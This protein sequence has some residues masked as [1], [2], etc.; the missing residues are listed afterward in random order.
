MKTITRI[1]VAVCL[2]S[3]LTAGVQAAYVE[4]SCPSRVTLGDTI[5]VRGES[6]LSPGFSTDVIFSWMEVTKKIIARHEITVQEGGDFATSFDTEGLDPG[7]YMVEI[8]DP[9]RDTFGSSSRTFQMVKVEDRS[10]QISITSPMTQE[11]D[12]TLLVEGAISGNTGTGVKIEVTGDPGVV[13][14]P[15]YIAT[16]TG[17]R[18]SQEVRITEPGEYEVSFSDQ[19]G[20]IGIETF[21]VTPAET[22]TTAQ[23]TTPLT[24]S[25]SASASSSRE[26]PAYF[27]IQARRGTVEVET[28]ADIDWVVEY[29]DETGTHEVI[30]EKGTITGETVSIPT[31]GGTI[32]LKVYPASWTEQGTARITVWNA[33]SVDVS[34][35]S[36][37]EFG[38]TVPT[39]TP[40]SP[41]SLVAVAGAPLAAA[42]AYRRVRR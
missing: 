4:L 37:A 39:T 12:G 19:E 17:G 31:T 41:L 42:G 14:G 2:L 9:T 34:P 5:G 1:W 35:S 6:T 16:D 18:F 23:P 33:I 29:I 27:A 36:A 20:F 3:L 15:R 10:S 8:V 32:H 30:N 38:D 22:P 24:P 26:H 13:F 25:L 21:T 28:S 11:F 40:A 7:Q